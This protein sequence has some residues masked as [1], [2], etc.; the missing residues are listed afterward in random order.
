MRSACSLRSSPVAKNVHFVTSLTFFSFRTQLFKFSSKCQVVT[1]KI[2]NL[3]II[4][5]F[6]HSSRSHPPFHNHMWQRCIQHVLLFSSIP[7]YQM[8]VVA[9]KTPS[10]APFWPFWGS[11]EVIS[12]F[13]LFFSFSSRHKMDSHIWLWSCTRF[14]PVKV[15]FA[16]FTVRVEPKRQKNRTK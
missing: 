16:D 12:L 10:A 7:A 5:A 4:P 8:R 11:F 13:L 15:S 3:S 9:R 1:G 2:G 14:L 6:D